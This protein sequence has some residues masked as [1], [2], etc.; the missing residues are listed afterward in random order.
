MTFFINY[1]LNILEVIFFPLKG[2]FTWGGHV[3]DCLLHFVST[4]L[5]YMSIINFF[6]IKR[7]YSN[8]I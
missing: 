4:V 2:Y 5:R 7:F 1:L 6:L 8:L 3:N